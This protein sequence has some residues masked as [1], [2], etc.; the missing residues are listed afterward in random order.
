MIGLFMKP[1]ATAGWMSCSPSPRPSPL[2]RGRAGDRARTFVGHQQ[3][4]HCRPFTLSLRERAG[5]R[6]KGIYENPNATNLLRP[7]RL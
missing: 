4:L 6:G 1:G 7:S 3:F 2:G 5:V